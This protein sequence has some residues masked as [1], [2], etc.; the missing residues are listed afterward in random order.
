M[1]CTVDKGKSPA[2]SGSGRLSRIGCGSYRGCCNCTSRHCIA[3]F[4]GRYQALLHPKQTEECQLANVLQICRLTSSHLRS[5]YLHRKQ[6]LS[7]TKNCVLCQLACRPFGN[8]SLTWLCLYFL[9]HLYSRCFQICQRLRTSQRNLTRSFPMIHPFPLL[10]L[11]LRHPG[12]SQDSLKVL[13]RSVRRVAHEALPALVRL[14]VE[15]RRPCRTLLSVVIA[16]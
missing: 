16:M 11:T 5:I 12:A 9:N 15:R 14:L 3:R 13:H 8:L 7:M 6:A 1:R 4:Q 2:G 10:H